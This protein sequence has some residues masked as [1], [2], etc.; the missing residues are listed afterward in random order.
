MLHYKFH[1]ANQPTSKLLVMLHGFISDQKAFDNHIHTL[2]ETVNVVTIDLPGHGED[3]TSSNQI[4]DFP[5]INN[6]L[7]KTLEMFKSHQLFLHGY[8]MG[9][10]IALYHAIYGS[11][12]LAGLVLESTSPGIKDEA[13]QLER[14]HV[15]HARARVLE[16]AGLEV[17]V[18][19]WEKLPLF[20]TQ[21]DL[22]ETNRS[23]IR[24]MRLRQDPVRLA[25]S[26]RDYGTGNMPNLWSVINQIQLPTCIIVGGLDRK[27][28]D[29]AQKMVSIMPQ[30]ELFEVEQSGHTVHVEEM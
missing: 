18:N 19:D 1:Q 2:I 8:S 14:Q 29:I 25:K 11:T 15:D 4:W 24:N 6:Q 9:G 3:Q 13:T 28:C 20:Y 7:N 21:Y 27:F 22:D 10:R 23:N 12:K 16:I 26:L 17:F 30:T 5:F